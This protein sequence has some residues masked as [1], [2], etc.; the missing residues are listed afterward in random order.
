MRHEH[1]GRSA[2]LP[3]Q[4]H[5]VPR[6]K[7]RVAGHRHGGR[8]VVQP[9]QRRKQVVGDLL[10]CGGQALFGQRHVGNAHRQAGILAAARGK[11]AVVGLDAQRRVVAGKVRDRRLAARRRG[12]GGAGL[13]GKGAQHQPPRAVRRREAAHQLCHSG[14]ALPPGGQAVRAAQLADEGSVRVQRGDLGLGLAQ[15]QPARRRDLPQQPVGRAL[16]RRTIVFLLQGQNVVIGLDAHIQRAPL[17]LGHR[18]NAQRHGL[19]PPAGQLQAVVQHE[20]CVVE[21]IAAQ[22]GAQV[23]RRLTEVGAAKGQLLP[24]DALVVQRQR[25]AHEVCRVQIQHRA[26]CQRQRARH[27]VGPRPRAD[28]GFVGIRYGIYCHSP[29]FLHIVGA[30][31][32]PP[33]AIP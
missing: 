16:H 19:P 11:A 28:R 9:L 2:V 21:G 6:L 15:R 10:P 1:L 30:G 27:P 18:V 14:G 22:V 23:E 32:A 33:A 20:L 3:R 4:R 17:G 31:H 5:A 7:R 24:R 8:D 26:V 13:L 25:P 29:R 12:Q